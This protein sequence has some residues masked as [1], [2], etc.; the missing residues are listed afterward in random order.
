MPKEHL[1]EV[2]AAIVASQLVEHLTVPLKGDLVRQLDQRQRLVNVGIL[3]ER[4]SDARLV[5]AK[6][7]ARDDVL[8]A[9]GVESNLHNVAGTNLR[10]GQCDAV[11][12]RE[13][14]ERA[15]T[16]ASLSCSMQVAK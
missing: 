13:F 11:A 16:Q 5:G 12:S 7:N 15:T 6:H 8:A 2:Q 3:V 1:C 14:N 9:A 4:N 10:R